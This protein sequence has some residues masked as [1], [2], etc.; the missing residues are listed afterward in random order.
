MQLPCE[1]QLRRGS[2]GLGRHAV[3][4]LQDA[5]AAFIE[6]F[7]HA[8]TT[9]TFTEVGLTAVLTAKETTCQGIIR[10][11]GQA[12]R[13]DGRQVLGFKL[14]PVVQVIKRLEADV[15]L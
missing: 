4:R 15:A 11:N 13:L 8:A 1:R 12:F 7:L 5:E 2:A 14:L 9:R 10:D 6:V 3:E